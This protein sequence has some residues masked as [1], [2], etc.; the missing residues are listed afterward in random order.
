MALAVKFIQELGIPWK[1]APQRVSLRKG[2]TT[3]V[4]PSTKKSGLND[5]AGPRSQ[6]MPTEQIMIFE[7]TWRTATST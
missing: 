7:T 4:K 3:A 1:T 5:G 2:L 6:D